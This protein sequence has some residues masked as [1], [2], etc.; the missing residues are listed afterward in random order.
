MGIGEEIAKESIGKSLDY[1]TQQDPLTFSFLLLLFFVL[2]V[3]VAALGALIYFG[4]ITSR[5]NREFHSFLKEK[6]DYF[7]N[8]QT[9][10]IAEASEKKRQLSEVHELVK[11]NNTLLKIL[12][13]N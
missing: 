9:S 2:L 4:Y 10:H 11:E 13:K 12:S 1:A 7:T 5:D 3:G 8:V 6:L